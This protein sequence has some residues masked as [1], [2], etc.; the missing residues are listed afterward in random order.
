MTLRN[1]R[2]KTAFA[3]HEIR[4]LCFTQESKL[5]EGR[6]EREWKAGGKIFQLP[7][8]SPELAVV[9]LNTPRT[10][11]E[12]PESTAAQE[13]CFHDPSHCCLLNTPAIFPN[14]TIHVWFSSCPGNIWKVLFAFFPHPLKHQDGERTQ[15][16]WW[17]HGLTGRGSCCSPSPLNAESWRRLAKVTIIDQQG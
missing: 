2:S 17:H 7:S 8:S 5:E 4:T 9:S 1:C 12:T 16:S 3:L 6:E 10:L 11:C 14:Q 13:L 15:S